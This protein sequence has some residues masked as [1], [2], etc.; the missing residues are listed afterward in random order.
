MSSKKKS[1][2]QS[3]SSPE[4]IVVNDEFILRQG[5]AIFKGSKTSQEL[6]LERMKKDMDLYDG[7]FSERER[8]YSEFLGADRL[9]IPKTYT[10]IQRIAV[11]V[12]DAFMSDPEE[13]VDIKSYKSIPFESL[14]IVKALMNYRLNSH[15]IDFYKELYEA[16][17]D[18]IRNMYCVFK[19]YPRLKT[20]KV[21]VPATQHVQ[22][23]DGSTMEMAYEKEEEH[24]TAYEPVLE[25]VPPE[26]VLF[27][28]RS[29]WK[30]YWKH[31]IVHKYRASRNDLRAQGFKNVDAFAGVKTGTDTDV[32]KYQRDQ[33]YQSP[34]RQDTNVKE[35][36]EVWV[37]Q[38]WDFLPYEGE[39]LQSCSYSLLGDASGPTVVGK[40]WEL[41]ELPYKNS[42]FE[43]NRPPFVLGLAYPEPHRLPGKS[44]PQITESLQ[45][46]TNAQRNQERE[47]V[48]RDLRKTLI[49]NR[50]ANVDLPS[51]L[52]RRI[53]GYAMADGPANQAVSE[54]SSS[55][56]AAIGNGAQARTDQD[57]YETGLPPN[58]LGAQT[59]QDTATGG[60]QQLVNANKKI[61]F[62]LKNIAFTGIIP[63]LQMVLRLEQTYCSD[64]FIN[65]VTGR[66]LGWRVGDDGYPARE[67]IQGDFDLKVSI[68][69]NKG[70][71]S[72]EFLLLL[73]RMN[74]YNAGMAQL[75]QLQAVPIQQAKFMNPT[76]LFEHLL[77]LKGLKNF[78]DYELQAQPPA[79][80]EGAVP[81]VASQTGNVAD[82]GSAVSQMSPAA[83][84]V[85]PGA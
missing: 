36:E 60:T 50:E 23:P 55:N 51:L 4:K 57:Y 79:P 39:G 41:N 26:D 72:N 24:I 10:N 84:G 15:P 71:Q 16:T 18:S 61:G 11:D 46:E 40:S 30:N 44:Y 63:A 6:I 33:K 54:V 73:D 25:C 70:A 9:F 82:A 8:K 58:V 45:K 2:D 38:T 28:A 19:V 14:Q 7:I 77:S 1:T 43:S 17:I 62:V 64:E 52:Q 66:T 48:A 83:P 3:S 12:I 56:S 67:A 42:E 81:G 85:L 78:S 5:Q 22:L 68:G 47:A 37:Y 49:I 80:Q 35:Q 75:V 53:G 59:N 76:P 29:T 13:I 34:F 32:V 20:E 65:M 69:M 21:K 27:S 74:Q 31:P